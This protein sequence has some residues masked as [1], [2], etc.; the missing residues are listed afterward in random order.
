MFS[1]LVVKYITSLVPRL[2]RPTGERRSGQLLQSLV[3][4]SNILSSQTGD[5]ENGWLTMNIACGDTWT[6][7]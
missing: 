7:N 5:G 3:Q 4:A 6:R 2:P 1:G